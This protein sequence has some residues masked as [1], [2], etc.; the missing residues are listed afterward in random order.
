MKQYR[1]VPQLNVFGDRIIWKI[2]ELSWWGRWREIG[3]CF[4][5]AMAD[6]FIEDM[7]KRNLQQDSLSKE[8]ERTLSSNSPT[9]SRKGNLD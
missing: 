8:H 9:V 3:S 2:E 4:D 5:K 7:K 1:T 6:H